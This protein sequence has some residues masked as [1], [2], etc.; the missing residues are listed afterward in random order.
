MSIDVLVIGAG[1]AGLA[2]ATRLRQLG[3]ASVVVLEREAEAGGIPR[4]S[5][6]TGYGVRDLRR[7]MTGPQYARTLTE[8]ALG[9]GIDL[10]THSMVTGWDAHG[11]ALVTSPRGRDAIAARAVVLA[12]GARERP[13]AARLVPGDRPTG[14]MTTGMLQQLVHLRHESVGTRAVVVGAELVSWSAVMT[15]RE[16]GCEVVAMTTQHAQPEVYRAVSALGRL[17]FAVPVARRT[18][19]AR[20]NGHGRVASV[21]LEHLDSGA[22]RVL[23]CD[24]VVF[25]GDWIPDFELAQL[26]GAALD[27]GT[28]GPVVDAGLRTS[29]PEMFA[30][31]NVVHPVDTAT[32][33]PSTVFTLPSRFSLSSQASCPHRLACR[34]RLTHRSDGSRRISYAPA[35]YRRQ[36]IARCCGQMRMLRSRGLRFVKVIAYSLAAG[37]RGRSRLGASS[38]CRGICSRRCAVMRDRCACGWCDRLVYS[39]VAITPTAATQVQ[40]APSNDRYLGTRA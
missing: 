25:T 30:V 24:T 34:S 6:H 13:R 18:R 40:R 12:T 4:H 10:R 14:V 15:L 32:W 16:A 1:P 31:G 11:A 39:V 26:R 2:A 37:C 35:M 29:V 5:D 9:S 33:R 22:R 3:V 7:V 38:G 20:I 36:G 21:E 8:R 27:S 23:E 19:I 17:R 28:R